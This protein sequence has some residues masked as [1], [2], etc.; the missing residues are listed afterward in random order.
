MMFCSKFFPAKGARIGAAAAVAALALSASSAVLAAP[1]RSAGSLGL[2]LK[3]SGSV[4]K[5]ADV[6]ISAADPVLYAQLN[7]ADDDGIFSQDN[8]AAFDAF[9]SQGADDFIVPAGA[10]W[11]V[12]RL[13]AKGFF[14]Q[15][16]LVAIT[17][18]RVEF[19]SA[20][21]AVPGAVVATRLVPPADVKVLGGNIIIDL[22][23]VD[24]SGGTRKKPKDVTYWVSVQPVMDFDT[25]GQWFWATREINLNKGAVWRN[26]GAGFDGSC[27]VYTD[28]ATCL[29]KSGKRDLLFEVRGITSPL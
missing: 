10:K 22:S 4:T 6:G 25:A 3:A 1:A 23:P 19:Y 15:P 20:A 2:S 29:D 5:R 13:T 11:S 9:D 24:L 7:K 16:D 18:V 14:T 21:G 28:L 12:S 26:P 27:V 17:G 8:E